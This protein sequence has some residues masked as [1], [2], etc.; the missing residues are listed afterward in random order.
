MKIELIKT[1]EGLFF[2]EVSDNMIRIY[3][4]DI[5]TASDIASKYAA[6][7]DK[8]FKYALTTNEYIEFKLSD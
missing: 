8:A 7:H 5:D 4:S 2:C 3:E 1:A 6:K